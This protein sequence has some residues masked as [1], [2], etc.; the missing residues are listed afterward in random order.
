MK[1]FLS[2]VFIVIS[3]IVFSGCVSSFPEVPE[4]TFTDKNTLILSNKYKVN[5]DNVKNLVEKTY[6]NYGEYP[7]RNT[8]FSLKVGDRY[9][10]KIIEFINKDNIDLVEYASIHGPHEYKVIVYGAKSSIEFRF[11]HPH[12]FV[13]IKKLLTASSKDK[14]YKDYYRCTDNESCLKGL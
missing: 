8:L 6:H 14:K 4:A 2:L 1:K 13:E 12:I 11:H 5:F 7:V 3:T 9:L 10:S